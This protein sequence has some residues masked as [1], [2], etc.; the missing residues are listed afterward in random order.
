MFEYFRIIFGIYLIYHFAELIPYASEVFG[1]DIPYD[2]TLSPLHGFFP[3]IIGVVDATVFLWMLLLAAALYTLGIAYQV[4]AVFLWY[5]WA[6]L[7]N[8]NIL[9]AN[10]GLP[11][12]G[13][14]L[15]LSAFVKENRLPRDYHLLCWFMMASGY[16]VSGIHKLWSPS[17]LDGTALY[18]V[19]NSPLAR[20]NIIRDTLLMFPE[21]LRLMTWFSLFLE[22]S[23]LPLGLFIRTRFIYWITY[24]MF[25]LGI[26]V[27]INFTDLTLGVLMIHLITFEPWWLEWGTDVY[28]GIKNKRVK[29]E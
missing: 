23:F 27:L 11:Y 26:I 16:T 19:L 1:D 18:H 22:I 6:C 13:W 20:D 3:N 8:R 5:G 28:Q 17:W 10:P 24:V 2:T 21:F 29:Y 14:M 25:H 12:V 15:L 9:I 7:F 4:M